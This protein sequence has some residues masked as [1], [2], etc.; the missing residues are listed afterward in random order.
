MR[1]LLK[2]TNLGL[3]LQLLLTT[4][5]TLFHND[6]AKET[7][8]LCSLPT[9]KESPDLLSYYD[10]KDEKKNVIHNSGTIFPSYPI[11]VYNSRMQKMQLHTKWRLQPYA[12]IYL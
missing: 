9:P 3:Q 4:A 5:A 6:P 11:I 10:E 7:I 12:Y 1:S 8:A 2:T